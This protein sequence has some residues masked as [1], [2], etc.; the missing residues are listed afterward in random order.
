MMKV[1]KMIVSTLAV[2]ILLV[3]VAVPLIGMMANTTGEPVYSDNSSYDYKM[4]KSTNLTSAITIEKTAD[5]YTY[6][7][8]APASGTAVVSNTMTF[9]FT[10]APTIVYVSG[11][12]AGSSAVAWST[13]DKLVFSGTSWTFTPGADSESPALSGTFKWI[14]YP[15]DSG[16]YVKASGGVNVD[17]RSEIVTYGALS[18]TKRCVTTGTLTSLSVLY[19]VSV[20]ESTAVTVTS[21]ESGYT[22]AVTSVMVGNATVAQNLIVPLQY[23]SDMEA[24]TLTGLVG[25]IPVILIAALIM[26]VVFRVVLNK[27]D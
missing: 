5:G 10:T 24:S 9:A 27:E 6:N 25:I 13:G 20:D 3:G 2:L 21:E 26:G 18:T 8:S 17:D 14:Y 19:G 16:T 22:N 11:G 12:T 7:G 1:N 4:A 15:D 23:T